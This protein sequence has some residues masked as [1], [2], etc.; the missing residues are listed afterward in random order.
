MAEE[1][2]RIKARTFT[3]VALAGATTPAL[4]DGPLQGPATWL[5]D[6]TTQNGDAIVEPGE[7]ATVTISMLIEP[8]PGSPPN[9]MIAAAVFDTLAAT[10]SGHIVG[11]KVLNFL[12]ELTGDLTT[13]DGVNLFD[14]HAGQLSVQYQ[15]LDNPV[16][17]FTFDWQPNE[18]APL[19]EIY[20]THSRLDDQ[21]HVAIVW[22][23]V[24]HPGKDGL[25]AVYP[26]TEAEISI[27]VI[28]TPATSLLLAA[29]A[30]PRPRRRN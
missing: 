29:A 20:T 5:W 14:T 16:D 6:V 19:T 11:W 18:Y 23:Y 15:T 27:S 21:E 12:E 22:E 26:I 24:D 13:T 4:A 3:S 8:D 7:T 2:L 25:T 28:P 10:S 17:V 30:A 1:L 9:A